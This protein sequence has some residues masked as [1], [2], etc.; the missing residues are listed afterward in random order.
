VRFWAGFLGRG[1]FRTTVNSSASN[2]WLT[3]SLVSSFWVTLE[4]LGV[5]GTQGSEDMV[6]TLRGGSTVG[7]EAGTRVG[8]LR[9][10]A[11][12]VGIGFGICTLGDVAG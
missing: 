9:G 1:R 11:M 10:G 8:T 6:D 7:V 2:F 12:G 5:R 3:H 4:V